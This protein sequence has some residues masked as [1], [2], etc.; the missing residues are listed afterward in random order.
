MPGYNV[1]DHGVKL[2][3]EYDGRGGARNGNG[4]NTSI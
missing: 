4:D 1:I 3:N 2:T